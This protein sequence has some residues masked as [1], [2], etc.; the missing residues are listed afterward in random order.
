MRQ[1]R[2]SWVH[3]NDRIVCYEAGDVVETEA[4]TVYKGSVKAKLN[5]KK[6]IILQIEWDPISGEDFEKPGKGRITGYYEDGDANPFMRKGMQQLET[7]GRRQSVH[8]KRN[9]A[10]RNRRY[11]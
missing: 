9:A 2:D 11:A 6:D 8:E 3:I 5:G 1:M 10:V 7:G 4:G